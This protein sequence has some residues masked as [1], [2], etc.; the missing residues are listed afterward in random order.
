METLPQLSFLR[1][2]SAWECAQENHEPKDCGLV[3]T[4][5][6]TGRSIGPATENPAHAWSLGGR[7]PIAF[8][9]TALLPLAIGPF[10]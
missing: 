4:L 3:S 9:V 10:I 6:R 1:G 8:F 7:V 5:H 2:M